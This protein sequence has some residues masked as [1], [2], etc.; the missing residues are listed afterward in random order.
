MIQIE[1]NTARYFELLAKEEQ[2]KSEGKNLKEEDGR[3]LLEWK[4]IF[5]QELRFGERNS[6][7][8]LMK[9]Y[10]EEKI[11]MG[12][13]CSRFSRL[14]WQHMAKCKDRREELRQNPVST[15]WVDSRADAFLNLVGPIFSLNDSLDERMDENDD[16]EVVAEQHR[17]EIQK[18]YLEIKEL[19][20]E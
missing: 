2:L 19:L 3:E 18:I 15:I 17:K 11:E 4:V 10:L 7:V 6:Y 8:E 1:K 20:Q 13:F 9:D 16:D 14:W 5:S 12:V